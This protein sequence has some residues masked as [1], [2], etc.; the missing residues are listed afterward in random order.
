MADVL[1]VEARLGFGVALEVFAFATVARGVRDEALVR[2]REVEVVLGFES[3]EGAGDSATTG[4]AT[5]AGLALA[6]VE[7]DVFFEALA[8]VFAAV[9]T[10][11][12]AEVVVFFAVVFAFAAVAGLAAAVE[13]LVALGFRVVVL[14]VGRFVALVGLVEDASSVCAAAMT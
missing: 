14:A 12:R 2:L 13:L 1:A 9:A 7:V 10:F 3:S 6:F 4:S 5:F 8:L 11:E